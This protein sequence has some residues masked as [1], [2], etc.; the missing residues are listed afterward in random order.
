MTLNCRRELLH[1]THRDKILVLDNG[2][3]AEVGTYAELSSNPQSR[4]TAFL[5]TITD[6]S[7]AMIGGVPSDAEAAD[8]EEW[9]VAS[10]D[11]DFVGDEPEVDKLIRGEPRRSSN[12]RI[13]STRRS[14]KDDEG[15][16]NNALMTDEFNEREKGSVDRRVYLAWARAGGGI[17]VGIVILGMYV[18]VEVLNVIS[19]WWLT[20]WSRTGGHNAFFFLGIYALVNFLAIFGTFCRQILFMLVGLR[21]SRSMFEQLL[22]VVLQA[23]MAFFDTYVF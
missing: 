11:A 5:K 1:Y 18:V 15:S 20:Y 8:A 3:V 6:T 13:S 22:D 9:D 14:V 21:A 4:F 17:S 7:T 19:K 2:C 12:I 10:G 23:P 16:D